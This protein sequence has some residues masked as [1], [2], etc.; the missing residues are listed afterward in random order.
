MRFSVKPAVLVFLIGAVLVGAFSLHRIHPRTCSYRNWAAPC[1]TRGF[2]ADWTDLSA[3]AVVLGAAIAAG[4]T[5][6]RRRRKASAGERR[7]LPK[8]AKRQRHVGDELRQHYRNPP[9]NLAQSIFL[10][11]MKSAM[12]GGTPRLEAEERVVKSLRETYPDFSPLRQ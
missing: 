4:V 11:T 12:Q 10:A 6:G 1:H 9:G 5:G 7:T 3:L 2:H 8:I